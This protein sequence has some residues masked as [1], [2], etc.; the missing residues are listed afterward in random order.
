MNWILKS[1]KQGEKI[2]SENIIETSHLSVKIGHR[3]ILKDINWNVKKVNVGLC[4][5]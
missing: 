4:L 5:A 3:Y 1:G 2:M